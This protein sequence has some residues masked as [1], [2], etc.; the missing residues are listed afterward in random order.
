MVMQA[1]MS[2]SAY[3]SLRQEEVTRE[4]RAEHPIM[5]QLEEKAFP[6]SSISSLKERNHSNTASSS[7]ASDRPVFLEIVDREVVYRLPDA[8]GVLLV[9][10]LP[11]IWRMNAG[12]AGKQPQM[13][14]QENSA[15]LLLINAK[16]P[17]WKKAYVRPEVQRVPFPGS[18]DNMEPLFYDEHHANN[19]C[20]TAT[21]FDLVTKALKI[22]RFLHEQ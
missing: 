7:H 3:A 22:S 13:I 6:L 9:L 19:A 8:F 12:R 14:P 17:S 2:W 16:K 10:G 5:R 21:A 18:V 1:W 11:W 4:I 15:V 20:H